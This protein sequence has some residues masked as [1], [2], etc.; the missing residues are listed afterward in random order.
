[1]LIIL[2]P[3]CTDPQRRHVLDTVRRR[4]GLEKAL[5]TFAAG[6]AQV[7]V[8]TQMVAKGHHFPGVTLTGVISADGDESLIHIEAP[9]AVYINGEILAGA[10][11]LDVHLAPARGEDSWRDV[12]E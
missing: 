8:G 12:G 9:E 5:G 3:S 7:L 2:S 10:E 11:C 6:N 1:M 4:D